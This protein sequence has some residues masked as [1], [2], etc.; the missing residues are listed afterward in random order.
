MRQ[1]RA[2]IGRHPGARTRDA[3]RARRDADHGACEPSLQAQDHEE[4]KLKLSAFHEK[5]VI[6]KRRFVVSGRERRTPSA[7]L[8]SAL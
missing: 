6:V 1:D 3:A 5:A 4:C 7:V 8:P 2:L